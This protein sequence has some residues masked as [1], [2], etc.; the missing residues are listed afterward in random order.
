[1]LPNPHAVGIPPDDGVG[2]FECL[3]VFGIFRT[4][5]DIVGLIRIVFVLSDE[6][7]GRDGGRFVMTKHVRFKHHAKSS[8]RSVVV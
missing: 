3:V 8:I 4:D 7:S 6:W 2:V 5:E 1:M